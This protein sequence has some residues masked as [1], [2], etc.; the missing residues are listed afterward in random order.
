M[1]RN[2]SLALVAMMTGIAFGCRDSTPSKPSTAV[3]RSQTPPTIYYAGPGVTAPESIPATLPVFTGQH[4]E[5]AE[6]K[7]L[8]AAVVD[9]TGGPRNIQV[10]QGHEPEVD[11]VAM[12]VVAADR[13][14]PGTHDDAPADVAVSIELTLKGCL[15]PPKDQAPEFKLE[16]QP[17]QKIKI[18]T[19][20]SPRVQIRPPVPLNLVEPEY[21]E[22]AKKKHITG[23]CDV[24][25]ILDAQGNPH[26]PRVIKS[27]D[28]SLD[29][30]ALEALMK[31]RFKPALKD[32]KIP[33]PLMIT[34]EV[35]FQLFD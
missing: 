4:C 5:K 35:N 28:P 2:S 10:L 34:I 31:Y 33:V 32:G 19:H 21:S 20:P 27:L 1:R 26:S 6:H 9:A 25:V 23:T 29:E 13:F 22:Y 12:E 30:K 18:L 14:R 3:E 7:V 15:F 24:S 11:L 8:V 17:E 16:S